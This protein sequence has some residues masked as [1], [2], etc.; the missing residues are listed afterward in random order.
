MQR[1]PLPLKLEAM[2]H[3]WRCGEHEDLCSAAV[4]YRENTPSTSTAQNA[5]TSSSAQ[6]QNSSRHPPQRQQ[7]VPSLRAY[8]TCGKW[9]G[10]SAADEQKPTSRGPASPVAPAGVPTDAKLHQRNESGRPISRVNAEDDEAWLISTGTLRGR[11]NASQSAV[12]SAGAPAVPLQDEQD[13]SVHLAA[14]GSTV[15][16]A[17]TVGTPAPPLPAGMAQDAARYQA[18][19][20]CWDAIDLL[21]AQADPSDPVR[22]GLSRAA[23]AVSLLSRA[24]PHQPTGERK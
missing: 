4:G 13:S 8:G 16:S 12:L 22:K 19:R 14:P 24:V 17:L 5:A 11:W 23:S 7:A 21:Y 20:E 15:P 6:R 9:S 2:K 18:M 1:P 10:R 3:Q